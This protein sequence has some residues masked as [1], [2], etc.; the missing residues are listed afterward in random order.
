[1]AKVHLSLF[2]WLRCPIFSL[3]SQISF[4]GITI[5][6]KVALFTTI[7][8]SYEPRRISREIPGIAPPISPV[9]RG[10]SSPVTALLAIMLFHFGHT[11][12]NFFVILI[13]QKA[14]DEASKLVVGHIHLAT[15]RLINQA[16]EILPQMLRILG[17]VLQR[18]EHLQRLVFIKIGQWT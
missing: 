18:L 15:H 16:V 17:S 5:Y 14:K 12:K 8:T 4:P 10:H 13:A 7:E 11:I 1:M 6:F 2:G 3:H 9:I